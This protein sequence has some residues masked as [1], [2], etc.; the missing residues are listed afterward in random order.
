M[1]QLLMESS[2]CAEPADRSPAP[3]PNADSL[4]SAGLAT[5]CDRTRRRPLHPLTQ[6]SQ[7]AVPHLRTLAPEPDVTG[8]PPTFGPMGDPGVAGSRH[9][10]LPTTWPTAPK[11]AQTDLSI[12]D[13]CTLP[14]YFHPR[15]RRHR[16]HLHHVPVMLPVLVVVPVHRRRPGRHVRHPRPVKPRQHR[17]E[18]FL[19]WVISRTG[20]HEFP[21]RNRKIRFH[22]V[23]GVGRQRRRCGEERD[24]RLHQVRARRGDCEA[25]WLRADPVGFHRERRPA[26]AVQPGTGVA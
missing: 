21:A 15:W 2:R 24:R 18:L 22:D 11:P 26:A 17:K 3:S 4:C 10:P 1:V 9:R 5:R 13:R 20:N 6:P 16:P 12:P 19:R 25:A 14:D 23:L 7:T 8:P